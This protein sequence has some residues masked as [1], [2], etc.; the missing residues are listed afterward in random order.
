MAVVGAGGNEHGWRIDMTAPVRTQVT[1][2][3]SSCD[4]HFT[5]SFY[6]PDEYQVRSSNSSF[7]AGR[8]TRCGWAHGERT[9]T[10]LGCAQ[11][12]HQTPPAPNRDAVWIDTT[13]PESYWVAQYAGFTSQTKVLEKVREQRDAAAGGGVAGHLAPTQTGA[14]RGAG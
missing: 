9:H 13:P 6:L 3:G 1:P 4:D 14:V 8:R 10:A 5:V 12:G 7:K 11:D 2:A